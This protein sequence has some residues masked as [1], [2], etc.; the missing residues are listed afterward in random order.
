MIVYDVTNE[1]TFE[2]ISTWFQEIK[3]NAPEDVVIMIV[4]NKTDLEERRAVSYQK[5]QKL[6]GS[7][8]CLFGE[9]SAKTGINVRESFTQMASQALKLQKKSKKKPKQKEVSFT[10]K[11]STKKNC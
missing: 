8:G 1:E 5:G 4:G 11:T 6:A 3:S 2:H 7:Y 10:K 9:M